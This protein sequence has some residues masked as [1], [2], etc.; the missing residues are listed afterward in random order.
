M[1]VLLL[2]LII[3]SSVALAADDR[4]DRALHCEEIKQK[5]RFIHSRMRAGYTRA[6]GERM[7]EELRR[8]RALRA[9]ACR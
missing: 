9:K 3:L 7:E 2:V 8:L 5:V 1:R 6:E 4:R